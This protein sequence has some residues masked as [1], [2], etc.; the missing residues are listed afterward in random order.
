MLVAE[1]PLPVVFDTPVVLLVADE[2]LAA[3]ELAPP[4]SLAT[5]VVKD[6]VVPESLVPDPV[7]AAAVELVAVEALVVEE[8]RVVLV[9]AVLVA[10]LALLLLATVAW[11]VV[12]PLAGESDP[13]QASVPVHTRAVPRKNKK[14]SEVSIAR[15]IG[16]VWCI[17]PF[18]G[19]RCTNTFERV[20]GFG[21]E[22]TPASENCGVG[23]RA[24]RR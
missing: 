10:A 8:P 15:V 11:L 22:A 16:S 14:R 12:S 13:A 18:K 23:K 7:V 19:R 17:V 5:P 20:R 6:P 1:P 24:D 9:L 3:L 2:L 4:V 21:S